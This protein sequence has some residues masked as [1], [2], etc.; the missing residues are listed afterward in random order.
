MM[1][2]LEVLWFKRP[3]SVLFMQDQKLEQ[4]IQV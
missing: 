3:I 2:G 1:P 4:A